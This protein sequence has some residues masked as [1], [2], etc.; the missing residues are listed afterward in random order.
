MGL[1]TYRKADSLPCQRPTFGGE[2]QRPSDRANKATLHGKGEW[3]NRGHGC[4]GLCGLVAGVRTPEILKHMLVQ[5]F[6]S[7]PAHFLQL[8]SCLSLFGNS[9]VHPRILS[10]SQFLGFLNPSCPVICVPFLQPSHPRAV[11]LN[12]PCTSE[13]LGGL[14]QHRS[15]VPSPESDAAGPGWGR[16]LC[17]SNEVLGQCTEPSP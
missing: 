1:G 6:S 14:F 3:K 12:I 10:S 15:P 13:S 9:A 7:L 16:T 5:P 4:Q 11:V 17:I 2:S 8:C